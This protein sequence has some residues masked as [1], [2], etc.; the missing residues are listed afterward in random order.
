MNYYVIISWQI[1]TQLEMDEH[2]ESR[3]V[4]ELMFI[5]YTFPFEC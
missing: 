3:W 2:E 4:D 1:Y 5:E